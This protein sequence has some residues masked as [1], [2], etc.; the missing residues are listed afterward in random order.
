MEELQELIGEATGLK[1]GGNAQALD[2]LIESIKNRLIAGE[3]TGDEVLDYAILHK[4][5]VDEGDF[6]G[7]RELK[8][9]LAAHPREP[10]IAIETSEKAYVSN[11]ETKDYILEVDTWSAVA[12]I[13]TL[14]LPKDRYEV[15][16]DCPSPVK[17]KDRYAKRWRFMG[18]EEAKKATVYGGAFFDTRYGA[19]LNL[20]NNRNRRFD[21]ETRKCS[22]FLW[23]S[24]WVLDVQNWTGCSRTRKGIGNLW[25]G[26][27]LRR[28]PSG[29]GC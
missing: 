12:V 29:E 24:R 1:D 10:F 8:H 28:N 19:E 3:T 7:L 20:V 27:M 9:R 18:P 22:V 26:C 23:N 4:G 16:F 13:D 14:R 21:G 15:V 2:A 6:S 25:E 5:R 17:R 11:P